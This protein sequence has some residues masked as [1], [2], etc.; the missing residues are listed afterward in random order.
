MTESER[1]H[2]IGSWRISERVSEKFRSATVIVSK[3]LRSCTSRLKCSPRVFKLKRGAQEGNSNLNG[4]HIHSRVDA[5]KKHISVDVALV[6]Q[7]QNK[8][9]PPLDL[10]SAPHSSYSRLNCPRFTS[11][12]DELADRSTSWASKNSETDSDMESRLSLEACWVRGIP[13]CST[14]CRQTHETFTV[15]WLWWQLRTK[16]SPDQTHTPS[17]D[18]TD[19]ISQHVYPC[20]RASSHPLLICTFFPH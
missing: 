1:G 14:A 11:F 19:F 20:Q 6:S 17:D 8:F 12:S 9:S 16:N 18:N 13:I 3:H 5:L 15:P 4:R 2:V 7:Q 10:N